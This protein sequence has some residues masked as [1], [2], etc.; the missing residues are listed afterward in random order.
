M[1]VKAHEALAM[2]MIGPIGRTHGNIGSD[3]DGDEDDGFV[4]TCFFF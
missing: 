2:V 4:R 1:V 3:Y